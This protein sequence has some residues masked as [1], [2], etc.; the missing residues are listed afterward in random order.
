MILRRGVGV[1]DVFGAK[2]TYGLDTKVTWQ[3]EGMIQYFNLVPRLV[4][5][6]VLVLGLEYV[7]ST[8]PNFLSSVVEASLL[9]VARLPEKEDDERSRAPE[10]LVPLPKVVPALKVVPLPKVVPPPKVGPDPKTGVRPVPN[11]PGEL[12]DE[13]LDGERVSIFGKLCCRFSTK[14]FVVRSS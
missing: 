11:A 14:I 13:V 2:G 12:N 9:T 4:V 5:D 8:C 10:A 6:E 1:S 7:L 3:G